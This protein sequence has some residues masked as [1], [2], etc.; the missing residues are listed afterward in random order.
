MM[1]IIKTQ[2]LKK[3]QQE[4]SLWKV[5]FRQYV[6]QTKQLLCLH[7]ARFQKSCWHPAD[8][9]PALASFVRN[10]VSIR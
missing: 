1:M 5:Y 9:P 10:T 2:L 6:S 3:R 8:A 7:A 4:S